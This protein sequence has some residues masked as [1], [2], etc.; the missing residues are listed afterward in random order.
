MEKKV[1]IILIFVATLFCIGCGL[2]SYTGPITGDKVSIYQYRRE[3]YVAKHP[4]LFAD[5]Q[6]KIRVCEGQVWIGMSKSDLKVV[7][8]LW[9]YPEINRTVT[10]YGVFEQVVYNGSYYYFEDGKLTA[11]QN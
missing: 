1:S 4:E 5:E 3:V 2:V 6:T 7:M 10:S 8:G 9:S 11:W